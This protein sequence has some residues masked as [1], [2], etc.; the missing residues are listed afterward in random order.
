MEKKTE[1]TCA[2]CEKLTQ[3][4]IIKAYSARGI[5]ISICQDCRNDDFFVCDDCD[6]IIHQNR[7]QSIY[8][9]DRIICQD[10]LDD[11]YTSCNNCSDYI[12]NDDSNHCEPCEAYYCE[13]CYENEHTACEN[14][15]SESVNTRPYSTDSEQFTGNTLDN[16]KIIKS[17]RIFSAEVECYY[18]N[19]ETHNETLA[20]IA[21]PFGASFDGSLDNKGIEFQ[22]PRLAGTIGEKAMRNFLKELQESSYYVNAKCG[23]HIHLD[24]NG[25]KN[26][27]NKLSTIK[28]LMMFYLAFEDAILSFLPESR[29]VNN[30]CRLL[31]SAYHIDEIK[32]TNNITEL[33]SLWYR[34]SDN[35]KIQKDYKQDNK[36]HSSRYY[37]INFHCLLSEGHLEIRYH[38]G[39]IDFQKIMEWTNLHCLIMDAVEQKDV[40]II[41]EKV[42]TT[43]TLTAKIDLLADF[44]GLSQDSKN[45]FIARA[46]KF[47]REQFLSE[48]D[49]VLPVTANQN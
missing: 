3:A 6:D 7:S 28:R 19:I 20:R 37:G 12:H 31:R 2:N 48:A 44:I 43:P 8:S 9:D 36:S 16:S 18:P 49:Y 34:E 35:E 41:V 23:L 45:Y 25:Y 14:D 42:M 11:N 17:S 30:Y 22:T 38:S 21:T 10:C 4:E 15:N 40:D 33:E 13:S 24:G 27:P 39:S 29:R 26:L 47:S 46:K 32:K 5:E 1:F